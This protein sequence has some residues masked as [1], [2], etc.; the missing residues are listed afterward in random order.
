MPI[1]FKRKEKETFLKLKEFIRIYSRYL[2]YF[3]THNFVRH[4]KSKYYKNK[5]EKLSLRAREI[6]DFSTYNG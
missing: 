4:V 1:L 2:T 6:P 3:V 5:L